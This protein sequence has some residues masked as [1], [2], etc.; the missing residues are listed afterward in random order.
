MTRSRQTADWG[1]RAGLAKIVPSSVAVGSGTGSAD[2]LGN[3]TFSGCSTVTLNGVFSSTYKNYMAF[4]KLNSQT[5]D[6]SYGWRLSASGTPTST[7]YFT[8]G[9]RISIAGAITGQAGSN[10]SYFWL[11]D[12]DVGNT[13]RTSSMTHFI[14]PNV[15]V[16]T[17]MYSTGFMTNTVGDYFACQN[18]GNQNDATSFDGVQ[19][20]VTA[21]NT[22]GTV[23]IYGYN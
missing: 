16:N 11:G 21:G 14:L 1:S 2:S 4:V 15:A 22:T 3:V 20:Y 17:H 13:E 8:G 12:L 7:L 18:N 23:S 9:L 5:S 6:G 19:L 10:V